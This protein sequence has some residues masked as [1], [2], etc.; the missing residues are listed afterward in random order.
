MGRILASLHVLMVINIFKWDI[1]KQHWGT[2][3]V[4]S[5]MTTFSPIWSHFFVLRSTHLWNHSKNINGDWII[6]LKMLMSMHKSYQVT[7]E[8]SGHVVCWS[9]LQQCLIL[10]NAQSVFV[11][12]IKSL[13]T[14]SVI[15]YLVFIEA[16]FLGMVLVCFCCTALIVNRVLIHSSSLLHD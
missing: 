13:P 3:Q 14:G 10:I 9:S 1:T 16:S 15:I 12:L 7:M 5:I 4:Y 11:R 8:F 6:S 2:M